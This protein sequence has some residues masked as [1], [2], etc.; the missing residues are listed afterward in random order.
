MKVFQSTVYP[1]RW[2][3]IDFTQ[4]IVQIKHSKKVKTKATGEP[5]EDKDNGAV[6]IIPFRSI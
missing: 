1:T 3:L 4:A 6:R 2:F 5:V